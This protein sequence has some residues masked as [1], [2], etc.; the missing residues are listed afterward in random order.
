MGK[1]ILFIVALAIGWVMGYFCA[2]Y[3]YEAGPLEGQYVRDT[4]TET[5]SGRKW[6]EPM[7]KAG[8]P[9]LY[10]VSDSLYR[11][12]QPD[13]EGMRQLEK[14]GV[15]TVINLR[16]LHSDSDELKGTSLRYEHI[17]ANPVHAEDEDVVKFLKIVTDPDTAPVFVHCRQGS[18][19]TGMMC[20]IYRIVAQGWSKQEA[21][22]EMTRGGFG[23]HD[24]FDNLVEYIDEL[25]VPQLR[26]EIGMENPQE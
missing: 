15:K 25:D 5:A 8:L 23:Y 24:E 3:L 6:A 2:C 13:E 22:D 1:V 17:W 26:R 7:Q 16:K 14:M 19:R 4:K 10:R 21:I 12:A 20:A 18:D 11:G 9:N